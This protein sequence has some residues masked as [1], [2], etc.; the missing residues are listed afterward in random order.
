MGIISLLATSIFAFLDLA[1]MIVLRSRMWR[2]IAEVHGLEWPSP[3]APKSAV[4]G[5]IVE[6]LARKGFRGKVD[7]HRPT[8]PWWRRWVCVEEL[9]FSIRRNMAFIRLTVTVTLALAWAPVVLQLAIASLTGRCRLTFG[10]NSENILQVC[11]MMRKGTVAAVVEWICWTLLAIFLVVLNTHANNDSLEPQLYYD[12]PGIP[13]DDVNY[14]LPPQQPNVL[15]ASGRQTQVPMQLSTGQLQYYYGHYPP[16]LQRPAGMQSQ[17]PPPQVYQQND[18]ISAGMTNQ[19]RVGRQM[20]SSWSNI[21]EDSVVSDTGRNDN[22]SMFHSQSKT[23]LLLQQFYH[24]QNQ[25]LQ[26]MHPFYPSTRI[27][28]EQ[29]QPQPSLQQ[30]ASKSHKKPVPGSTPARR[31]VQSVLHKDTYPLATTTAHETTA[32]GYYRRLSCSSSGTEDQTA[33]G[34]LPQQ[35]QALARTLC[36]VPEDKSTAVQEVAAGGQSNS[37][38][39]ADNHFSKRNTIG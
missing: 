15:S 8:V 17:Q 11:D 12:F 14:N 27:T 28:D 1:G 38:N 3:L 7:Q 20:R 19:K 39:T 36:Q 18:Q 10:G 4:T 24:L 23:Q 9:F 22:Q 34:E 29:H 37:D 25:Q 26:G 16:S 30:V 35:R 6:G 5:C 33:M 31:R 21:D 32:A 13:L 2:Q